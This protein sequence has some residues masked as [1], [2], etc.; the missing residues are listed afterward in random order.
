MCLSVTQ[1]VFGKE[2]QKYYI[3]RGF[4]LFLQSDIHSGYLLEYTPRMLHITLPN[5][6]L[7]TIF[8]PEASR[9]AYKSVKLN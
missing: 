6:N 2:I 7:Q 1:L 8:Q 9:N 5:F 3:Y 4:S